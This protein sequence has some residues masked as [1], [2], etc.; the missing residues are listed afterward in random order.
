MQKSSSEIQRFIAVSKGPG[1]KQFPSLSIARSP[2]LVLTQYEQNRKKIILQIM[3]GIK[4]PGKIMLV[5]QKKKE[6]SPKILSI[7]M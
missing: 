7:R 1:G 5:G 6:K 2:T 3:V 4:I